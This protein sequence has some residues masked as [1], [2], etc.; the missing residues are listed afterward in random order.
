M[1]EFVQRRIGDQPTLVADNSLP[2]ELLDWMPKRS[3]YD[4]C[5]DYIKNKVFN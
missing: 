2:L 1:Y 3:L 5:K 4:M